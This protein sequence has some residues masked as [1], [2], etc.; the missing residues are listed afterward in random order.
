MEQ[1]ID[2]Q[3]SL[4]HEDVN[5]STSYSSHSQWKENAP[6]AYKMEAIRS[7]GSNE[8]PMWIHH[9]G[10]DVPKTWSLRK[11]KAGK[12]NIIKSSVSQVMDWQQEMMLEFEKQNSLFNPLSRTLHSLT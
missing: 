4:Q 3:S 11:N 2:D 5:G 7:S 6:I 1:L 10:S 8:Y 12:N 9:P